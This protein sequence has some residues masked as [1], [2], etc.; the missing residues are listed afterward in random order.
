MFINRYIQPW[1]DGFWSS[2]LYLIQGDKPI[3]EIIIDDIEGYIYK[4]MCEQQNGQI[5]YYREEI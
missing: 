1:N 3:S 5:L 4:P 2:D